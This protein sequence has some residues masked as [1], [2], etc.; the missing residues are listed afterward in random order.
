M[1]EQHERL[2]HVESN[3]V[4]ISLRDQFAM[5]ALQGILASKADI[6]ATDVLGT[7]AATTYGVADAMMKARG[8]E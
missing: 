5:A 8:S 3:E 2:F 1:I 4:I 7:L 6:K